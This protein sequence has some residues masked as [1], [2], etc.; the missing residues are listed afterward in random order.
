MREFAAAELGG[1]CLEC[2]WNLGSRTSTGTFMRLWRSIAVDQK[3]KERGK[4]S[5][6][7]RTS[8]RTKFSVNPPP[9]LTFLL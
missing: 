6:R 1:N 9:C 8:S 3:R 4:R 5:Y 2:V 7:K